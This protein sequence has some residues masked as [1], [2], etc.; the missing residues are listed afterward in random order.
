VRRCGH[1]CATLRNRRIHRGTASGRL[2]G[3]RRRA[4]RRHLGRLARKLLTQGHT[5]ILESGFWLRSD[6]DEKRLG[7]R[8]L[9]ARVELHVLD[10]DLDELWRRLHARNQ[11]AV[12]GTVPATRAQLDRWAGFFEAPD[13]AEAHPVRPAPVCGAGRGRAPVTPTGRSARRWPALP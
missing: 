3:H 2:R 7:A 9:G 8:A 1:C 13:A 5:V 4:R 11:A 10:V 6:R 12:P